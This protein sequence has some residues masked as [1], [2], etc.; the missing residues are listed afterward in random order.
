MFSPAKN[1]APRR[2]GR[3]AAGFTLL[4]VMIGVA[5]LAMLTY[6][7][8]QFVQTNLIAVQ[9]ST[10]ASLD[11]QSM[12]GLLDFVQAE[13]TEIP[14]KGQ[15]VLLGTASKT[16]DLSM[17]QM[18]WTCKAGQG[19]L[20]TSAAGEYYVTLAIQ[21]VTK[22]SRELAIGLRRRT[23]SSLESDYNW[24]PL[25]HPAAAMEIRYYDPRLSSW[26]ERWNDQ[27]SRPNLV[28]IRIWKTADA[29][30]YEAILSVPAANLQ[31]L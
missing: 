3:A 5:V 22:N 1:S 20:T 7:V 13:M 19:L 14:A 6:T 21:A 30:P 31:T 27:N 10:K 8:Y 17:D 12:S 16:G 28:R 18:Q 11:R 2:A 9:Y 24:L 25:L 26:L 4:E 29:A 15:G 23:T